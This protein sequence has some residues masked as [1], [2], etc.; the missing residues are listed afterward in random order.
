MAVVV[1]CSRGSRVVPHGGDPQTGATARADPRASG[2][3]RGVVGDGG[4]AARQHLDDVRTDDDPATLFAF[5]DV[6]R[7][8]HDAEAS[9]TMAISLPLPWCEME[10][11]TLAGQVTVPS[12][13]ST[14]TGEV[15]DAGSH[16]FPLRQHLRAAALGLGTGALGLGTSRSGWARR[17]P[18]CRRRLSPGH[19]G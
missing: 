6:V 1:W 16:R 18:Q 13:R 5:V 3:P 8:A 4:L 14:S 17:G 12:S 15:G 10:A 2:N 9:A 19:L 7:R 11:V